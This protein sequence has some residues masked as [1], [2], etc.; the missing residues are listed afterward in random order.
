MRKTGTYD[1][2]CDNCR[3]IHW[4]DVFCVI[5]KL[6][7]AKNFQQHFSSQ[8]ILSILRR[9]LPSSKGVFKN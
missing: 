4:L 9:C 3:I 5:I 6:Y 8:G 1:L 7:I 2:H